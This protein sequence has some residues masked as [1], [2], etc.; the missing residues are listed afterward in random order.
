[1]EEIISAGRTCKIGH[2]LLLPLIQPNLVSSFSE[3]FTC[4]SR[5]SL[6]YL[7]TAGS[8]HT[9]IHVKKLLFLFDSV[10]L[11]NTENFPCH[12]YLISVGS[13]SERIYCL[14]TKWNPYGPTP[15]SPACINKHTKLG[16][17][18]ILPA[19]DKVK[20]ILLSH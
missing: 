6:K 13:I 18:F 11:P 17:S 10:F 2:F 19:S 5:F 16:N 9:W 7:F 15:T 1:M 4:T 20:L 8:S 14:W 3:S 12:Y